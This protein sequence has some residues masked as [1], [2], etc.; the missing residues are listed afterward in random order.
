MLVCHPVRYPPTPLWQKGADKNRNTGKAKMTHTLQN[1]S[2]I[3]REV[4]HELNPIISDVWTTDTLT[5]IAALVEGC[6]Y[7]I[8]EFDGQKS[9]TLQ[10]FYLLSEAVSAALR[11]EIHNPSYP[12]SP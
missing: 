7:L 5:G 11:Y 10:R 9:C 4:A 2:G 6:G 12:I 8:S 1:L 3:S